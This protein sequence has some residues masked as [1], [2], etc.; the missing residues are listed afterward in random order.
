[1]AHCIGIVA[2]AATSLA[3]PFKATIVVNNM[4]RKNIHR[5]VQY[6]GVEATPTPSPRPVARLFPDW[7]PAG[8]TCSSSLRKTMEIW[9]RTCY[10]EPGSSNGN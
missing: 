7:T 5:Q 8:V 1:L 9:W 10:H 4:V 2:S 3:T 6:S